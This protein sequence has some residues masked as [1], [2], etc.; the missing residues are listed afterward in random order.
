MNQS[1]LIRLFKSIEGDQNSALIKIAYS[2]IEEKKK[3]GHTT[4][5]DKLNTI[6]QNSV[7]KTDGLKPVLKLTKGSDFKVPIDRR[8]RLQ[9]TTHVEHE[10]LRHDRPLFC[11]A[12]LI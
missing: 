7:S 10:N 11:P 3:K 4:L 9:L 12:I 8:Y 1:L 5:P 2:I 6:L